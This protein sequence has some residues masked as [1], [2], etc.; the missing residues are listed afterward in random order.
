MF[1]H[2]L[3]VSEAIGLRLAD[4]DLDQPTFHVHRLKTSASGAH[5][6]YPADR[7]A[8]SAWLKV[9]KAM[10][11]NNDFLFISERRNQLDR[12]SV[13]E[14]VRVMAAAAKLDHLNV[15]PHSF[16][17]ACGYYLINSGIDVRR[18]QSFLGHK[19][20]ETTSRYTQ[21]AANGF[22]DFFPKCSNKP[23]LAV[24]LCASTEHRARVLLP[25]L[26]SPALPAAKGTTHALTTPGQVYLP[27]PALAP[28]ATTGSATA[29]TPRSQ[30]PPAPRSDGS[31]TL[32]PSR[33]LQ[34]LPSR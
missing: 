20:I 25:I 30:T 29:L 14:I 15:H 26:A 24:S 12:T 11:P 22:T 6:I 4:I 27:A 1:R 2:G 33:V 17:H 21:L 34:K 28:G 3:R 10:K 7:K 23:R 16:R 31:W 13:W 5:P 8:L 18:A 32:I 9:R 19:S